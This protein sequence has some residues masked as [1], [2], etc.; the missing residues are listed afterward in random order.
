MKLHELLRSCFDEND[1]R[2]FLVDTF[3]VGGATTG[4]DAWDSTQGPWKTRAFELAEELSRIGLVRRQ[5]FEAVLREL[6]NRADDISAACRDTT[7]EPLNYAVGSPLPTELF[8]WDDYQQ[9]MSSGLIQMLRYSAYDARK[10]GFTTVSTSELVRVYF[11]L[12][13]WVATSLVA[14]DFERS[15]LDGELDPFEDALG[16]SMCVGKTIHGLAKFTERPK[17]F[18][19]HDVFLDLVRF[20]SGT[21]ARKLAPDGDALDAINQL[22][23]RLGIGRVT[24]HGILDEP[25]VAVQP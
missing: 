7:G 11:E 5:F 16:A 4:T 21:S 15:E 3:D 2:I 19:E 25:P 24:R 14:D 12:Q 9:G 8:P 6:P 17:K 10:R 1:C 18:T 23:R 22:S 20:G 13:P